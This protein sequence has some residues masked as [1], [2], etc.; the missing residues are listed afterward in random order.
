MISLRVDWSCKEQFAP[1][2]AGYARDGMIAQLRR[3]AGGRPA[4]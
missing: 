4:L 3:E 2:L 1:R